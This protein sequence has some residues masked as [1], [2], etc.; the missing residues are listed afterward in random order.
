MTYS[1]TNPGN[2]YSYHTPYDYAMDHQ[3]RTA[4]YEED[5]RIGSR[6][7]STYSRTLELPIFPL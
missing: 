4:M 5:P 7:S 6:S 2:A 3:G 1:T